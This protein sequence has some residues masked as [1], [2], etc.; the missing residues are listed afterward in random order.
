VR[1]GYANGWSS[2]V[3]CTAEELSEDHSYALSLLHIPLP[4]A[5]SGMSGRGQ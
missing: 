2:H 5:S 3:D 4:S 1:R